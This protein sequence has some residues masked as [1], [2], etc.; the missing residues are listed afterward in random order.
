MDSDQ[1]WIVAIKGLLG[2]HFLFLF[3]VI[4]E[5]TVIVA[6]P[7]QYSYNMHTALLLSTVERSSALCHH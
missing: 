3:E 4:K 5:Q 7:I 2:N 1:N 6:D